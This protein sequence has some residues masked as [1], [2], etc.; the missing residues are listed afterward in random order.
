M[1][2]II[3][4]I[5]SAVDSTSAKN[6]ANSLTS[7]H[8]WRFICFRFLFILNEYYNW[9]L[10]IGGG[11]IFEADE[12]I[13][14]LCNIMLYINRGSDCCRWHFL[15]ENFQCWRVGETPVIRLDVERHH[16][17][18]TRQ[19][20]SNFDG[21]YSSESYNTITYGLSIQAIFS[22]FPFLLFCNIIIV[23]VSWNVYSIQ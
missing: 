14:T 13:A 15:D 23:G 6:L 5:R 9:L 8:F 7:P 20:R 21:T 22:P 19:G 4:Q 16:P 2:L 18:S 1:H 3:Q 10:V 12:L 17:R 11:V